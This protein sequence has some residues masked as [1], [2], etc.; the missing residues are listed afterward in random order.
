[1]INGNLGTGNGYRNLEIRYIGYKGMN[2]PAPRF[3]NQDD[4]MTGRA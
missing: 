1:M 4:L 3:L 2:N